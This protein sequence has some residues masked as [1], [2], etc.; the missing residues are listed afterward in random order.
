MI[1]YKDFVPEIKKKAGFIIETFSEPLTDTLQQANKWIEQNN[2][3]II[4]VE[5]VVLPNIHNF[6]EEGSADTDIN[7]YQKS[8][9]NWHQIIRVWYKN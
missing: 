8:N 9:S 5:T 7:V 6:Q 3:N 2:V 1:E 4:N